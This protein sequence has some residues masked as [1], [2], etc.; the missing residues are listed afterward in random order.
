L[1]DF[2]KM[3]KHPQ[4]FI[5]STSVPNFNILLIQQFVKINPLTQWAKLQKNQ[6]EFGTQNTVPCCKKYTLTYCFFGDF[7]HWV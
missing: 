3:K 6:S 4:V 1:E 2:E 7:A 5:Q